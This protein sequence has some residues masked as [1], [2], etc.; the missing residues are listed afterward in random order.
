MKS[1]K[2]P[3]KLKPVPS[4][5]P[6]FNYI[7]K[8]ESNFDASAYEIKDLKRI[9]KFVGEYLKHWASDFGVRK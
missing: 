3:R 6:V 7:T 4:Q 8:Q 1:K 5:I 2:K 9:H